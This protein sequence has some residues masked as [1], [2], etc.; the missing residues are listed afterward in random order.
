MPSRQITEMLLTHYFEE[1]DW[2][3]TI[4]DQSYFMSMYRM[5]TEDCA[6]RAAAKCEQT[7]NK[8]RGIQA[9]NS[10]NELLY[11]SAVLMQ[12]L[13]LSLQF[14]PVHS[15]IGE[16]LDISS[17]PAADRLSR[18]YSDAG[19]E[20]MSL[21]GRHDSAVSAV[22]ADLIRSAWLK[23]TGRGNEAWFSLADAIR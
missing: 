2:Y 11:F 13:A 18:V 19:A 5:W 14:L 16:L 7:T 17:L 4:V 20:V 8:K 22:L 6:Q 23:N 3:F 10:R 21:L 12:V 1:A 9:E 15:P